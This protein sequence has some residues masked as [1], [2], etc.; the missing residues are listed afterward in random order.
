MGQKTNPIVMRLGINRTWES[1]WC[2]EPERYA[3]F[4]QQDLKIKKLIKQRFYSAGVAMT[5]IERIHKKAKINVFCARPG[6][7]IGKKGAELEKLKNDLKQF[8]DHE[9]ILNVTEVKKPETSAQLVAENIC[10]QLEKMVS[11]RRAVKK[12]ISSAMRLS[13]QGIKIAASGRLG[14][15]EIARTESYKEGRIPLHTLRANI[16]YGSARAFTAYGTCGIKVW[17]Y[18]GNV[19]NR[20]VLAFDQSLVA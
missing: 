13:V 10:T 11:Y 12:S 7:L 18:K 4:L 6:S 19:Y 14:G 16:D 3:Y 15:I 1:R 9:I 20:N 5:V 17:I 8:T 2:C